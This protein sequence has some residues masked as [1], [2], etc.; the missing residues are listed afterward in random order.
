MRVVIYFIYLFIIICTS[1]IC[2]IYC[3]S[4]QHQATASVDFEMSSI[5]GAELK[6][7]KRLCANYI[8][9]RDLYKKRIFFKNLERQKWF[10]IY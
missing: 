9:R 5:F 4:T 8:K 10:E 3:T 6:N 1:K 7:G 2:I